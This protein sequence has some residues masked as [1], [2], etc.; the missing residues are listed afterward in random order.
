MIEIEIEKIKELRTLLEQ[1]QRLVLLPH[2]SPDG[3][4]L[5]ATGALADV[6]QSL[7]PEKEIA[8]VSPDP[9]EDYLSWLPLGENF[10]SFQDQKERAL[11]LVGEADL[12]LHL[13]HNQVKRV[14][15]PELIEAIYKNKEAKR[16]LIDH[17]ELPDKDFDLSLSYPELSST[18]ELTFMIIKALEWD[19]PFVSS[20]AATL[21]LSG[22]VTD[23][24]RFM[25][26]CFYPEIFQHFSELLALGANYPMIV[27][28][29]SYHNKEAQLRLQGYM[30]DEKME[31]YPELGA[32][33]LT[34][35]QEEMQAR[36]LSKGD[37]E[38]LVN[39]PLTIEGINTCCFIRE[40][41]SQ[42][43]LSFR[44]IGDFP[45][46]KL[47]MKAFGGGG[48]INAAGGEFQGSL[49]DAKNIYLY[50]LKALLEQ[51]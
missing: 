14:R 3:D 42:V 28:R 29:L 2:T 38:G 9:V 25:Y 41:K 51:K 37:T 35:S 6:L 5:G 10:I 49:N 45:V 32:A 39:L 20:K 26:A 4:A 19:K 47:A 8:I 31:L 40:D 44:S 13:D 27:D 11:Q 7:A 12:I 15:Y 43:K 16:V 21:L 46:N 48:H 30:L 22:I 33:V 1:S 34:L 50:E 23:T 18:C 17:H 24:G 36:G